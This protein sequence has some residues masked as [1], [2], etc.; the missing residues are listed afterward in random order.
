MPNHALLS[1]KGLALCRS[2]VLH[3][4][5]FVDGLATPLMAILKIIL[6]KCW[7]SPRCD[8]SHLLR[9]KIAMIFRIALSSELK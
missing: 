6:K 8:S 4:I 2:D 3:T 1:G 5:T 9:I 7:P